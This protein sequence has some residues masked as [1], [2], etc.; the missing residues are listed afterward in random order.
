MKNII[1]ATPDK[2]INRLWSL[3]FSMSIGLSLILIATHQ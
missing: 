3:F 2:W 1:I